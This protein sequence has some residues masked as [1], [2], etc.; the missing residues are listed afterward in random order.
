MFLALYSYAFFYFSKPFPRPPVF[1]FASYFFCTLR[2]ETENPAL[3]LCLH[4]Q[5]PFP[6]QT[7]LLSDLFPGAL[8]AAIPPKV[9]PRSGRQPRVCIKDPPHQGPN[10]IRTKFLHK[11]LNSLSPS[12]CLRGSGKRAFLVCLRSRRGSIPLPFHCLRKPIPPFT[13]E[14]RGDKICHLWLLPDSRSWLCFWGAQLAQPH[15]MLSTHIGLLRR[16]AWTSH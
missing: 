8:L 3:R 7:V 5:V 11:S 6:Q 16:P 2:E 10:L 15:P 9:R 12:L 13:V 14:S 4:Q 1:V